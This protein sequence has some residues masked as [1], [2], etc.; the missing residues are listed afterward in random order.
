M[1]PAKGLFFIRSLEA[2]PIIEK[3]MSLDRG[4]EIYRRIDLG[5]NNVKC[6]TLACDDFCDIAARGC[7]TDLICLPSSASCWIPPLHLC[8]GLF[9]GNC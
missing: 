1:E 8:L 5:L 3:S 7:S 9:G 6:Q 2:S 4:K